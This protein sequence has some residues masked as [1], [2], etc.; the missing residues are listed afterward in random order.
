M[1]AKKKSPSWAAI[2]I[3][4]IIFWPVSIYLIWKKI[5]IDKAAAMK[6]SKVLKAIGIIFVVCAVLMLSVAGEDPSTAAFGFLFYGIGGGLIIWGSIKVKQ[7]GER[8]KKYIDIV[9]NQ[10]QT[11]IENIASLMGLSYDQT[12]KGLQKMID[13]GYFEGTYIDHANHELVFPERQQMDAAERTMG[14]SNSVL[15]Q[16]TVKCP[17]CGGNNVIVAGR[18]CE[19]DFC[20]SPIQ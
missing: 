7:S 20:G 8:Y 3:W 2:V 1:G 6:F 11:T 18:V 14:T 10:N 4:F 9:I 15:Q 19:C 12:V 5:S 16:K 13:V 17:N